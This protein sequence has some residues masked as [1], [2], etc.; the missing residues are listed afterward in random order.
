MHTLKLLIILFSM[1]Y[2]SAPIY[3]STT[4]DIIVYSAR[5]AHLV[6]PLFD[7]FYED[8]GINVKVLTGKGSSIIE[9]LKLEGLGSKAD[10]LITI[11]AGNLWYAA[12]QGLFQSIESGT[13]SSNIPS[14]LR[15]PNGLWTGLSVR[16][17]TIIYNT[18]NV[19]PDNLSTYSDLASDK[20][21][22]RLCLRTSKK[23][24]TKSLVASLIFNKGAE[25]TKSIVG[26]WVKNLAATPNS[27]D[28][29][30]IKAIL[31]GQCDVGIVNSYYFHR[32][33]KKNPT[34]PINLFWANQETTGVHV[35]ISGAG[36]LKNSPN[37]KN[38]ILLLE[39]LTSPSAQTIF[40][41]LNNEFPA[42]PIISVNSLGPVIANVIQDKMNLSNVGILQ[43]RAVRLMQLARYR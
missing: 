7:A 37:S 1:Q 8:T 31:S 5:K 35:N 20:W 38:A 34:A 39:W 19:N 3:A 12:S 29:H 40:V 42:N 6:K 41:S 17:R 30:I 28:S 2:L 25:Q 11:D 14:H 18:D 24:Y 13:I 16:A 22:G 36:I 10:M 26:G 21:L 4:D 23:I 9:R 27:K 43:D 33:V 32:F 15:E